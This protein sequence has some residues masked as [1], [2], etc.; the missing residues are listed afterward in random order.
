MRLGLGAV[1]C[2]RSY[3][4]SSHFLHHHRRRL[5]L[6]FLLLLLLLL[7]LLVVVVDKDT[8]RKLKM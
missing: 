6:L 7:L 3:S 4:C 2:V 8:E 5:L 1:S